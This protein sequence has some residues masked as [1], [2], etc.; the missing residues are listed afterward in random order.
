MNFG[1]TF[2]PGIFEVDRSRISHFRTFERAPGD[3]LI[4]FLVDNCS[5]PFERLAGRSLRNPV[6]A[7][8]LVAIDGPNG[9][10]V[11]HELG[12][13]T[14][15]AP[16]TEHVLARAAYGHR[17]V[18]ANAFL[19]RNA[20]VVALSRRCLIEVRLPLAG[21]VPEAPI[22]ARR[23][24]SESLVAVAEAAYGSAQERDPE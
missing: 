2:A 20:D 16:E 19:V 12:N 13:V 14:E 21:E 9:L 10:D 22:S 8:A 5:V 15:I 17:F 18:N 4:F 6:R 1:P 24:N 11:F 3:Q 23:V 7:F